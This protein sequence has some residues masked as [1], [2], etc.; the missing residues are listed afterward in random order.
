MSD[1]RHS[2]QPASANLSIGFCCAEFNAEYVDI[3]YNNCVQEL[4]SLGVSRECIDR[5]CV[6]GSWELPFAVAKMIQKDVDVVI[7]LGVVIRGQTSH[8]DV[9]VQGVNNGLMQLQI[10]GET[11]I[12]NGILTCDDKQ[13][14]EDRLTLGYEFAKAA[15]KM[16]TF[17]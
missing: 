3:L 4:K 2:S 17:A 11:P 16:T 10:T 7:C 13:Q 1:Y 15:I 9:V 6:P 5:V 14:V 12:I 8:F